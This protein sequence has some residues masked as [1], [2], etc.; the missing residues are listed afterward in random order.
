MILFYY[1]ALIA[2]KLEWLKSDVSTH[3]KVNPCGH[4]PNMY[5]FYRRIERLPLESEVSL[6]QDRRIE[7]KAESL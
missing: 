2:S 3:F 6:G 5:L 7:K 1:G 4:I